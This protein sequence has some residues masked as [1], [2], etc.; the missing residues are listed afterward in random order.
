MTK[1]LL[2]IEFRY[3]DKPRGNWDSEHKTKTITIGV[4]DTLDE[5]I[6]EGNKALDILSKK[7]EVRAGDKFKLKYLFNRPFHQRLV[8]NCCYPTNGIQFF[9]KI[10]TLMFEDLTEAINVTFKAF[11]RYKNYKNSDI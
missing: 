11:D 10:E 2:T 3:Y 4:F 9:A 5:A 8:T 6:I 7:F 1:E